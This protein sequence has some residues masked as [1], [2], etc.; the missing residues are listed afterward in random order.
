MSQ[1][2]ILSMYLFR[3]RIEKFCLN[4]LK[5]KLIQLL[6]NLKLYQVIKISSIYSQMTL[7]I[8]TF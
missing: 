1:Y 2:I 7:D 8:M 3:K 6:L 4:L 5:S